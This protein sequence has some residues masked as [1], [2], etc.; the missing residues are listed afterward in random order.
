MSEA[1][2]TLGDDFVWGVIAV[3]SRDRFTVQQIPGELARLMVMGGF[4]SPIPGVRNLYSV[5]ED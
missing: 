5:D 4:P 2:R 3:L 1:R